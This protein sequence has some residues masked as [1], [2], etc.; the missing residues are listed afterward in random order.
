MVPSEIHFHCAMT[1]TPPTI[2]DVRVGATVIRFA[3]GLNVK[4]K[5]EKSRINLKILAFE[6]LR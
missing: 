1:G 2:F 4:G 5:I 3:D 6:H